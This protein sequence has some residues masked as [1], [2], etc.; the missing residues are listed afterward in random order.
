ALA[1]WVALP[2]E[3]VAGWAALAAGVALGVRLVR[4]QGR[5]TWHEPLLWV[6]HLGYGWLTL[7]F[8]L[9]A[10]DAFIPILPSTTALHALTVGAIGTVT[11]AM[12]TRVS[13][14]HTG[15]SLTAGRGTVAIYGMVSVAA[16]LRLLAP[17]GGS[18][19]LLLLSLA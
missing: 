3:W 10:F 15:R 2:D 14:G 12:M 7:G 5:A 6:L 4:W 18:Q 11:L 16:L 8:L 13:K 17:L 1:L 9:L 19:Y